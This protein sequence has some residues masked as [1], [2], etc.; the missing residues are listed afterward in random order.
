MGVEVVLARENAPRVNGAPD[1]QRRTYRE[2]QR[3]LVRHR[4]RSRQ[5]E[6]YRADV[7]VGRGPEGS[8]AAAEHLRQGAQLHVRLEPDDRLPSARHYASSP[9]G[10][11]R[12]SA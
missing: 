2:L 9:A 4:E 11:A 7:G 12:S 10:T 3:L 5:A 1:S 8:R 6:A